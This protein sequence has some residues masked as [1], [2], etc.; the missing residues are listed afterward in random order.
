MMP[1]ARPHLRSRHL[2]VVN[3]TPDPRM[4]R[5][6]DL[7]GYTNEP[8]RLYECLGILGCMEDEA[9]LTTIQCALWHTPS[10]TLLLSTEVRG[11]AMQVATSLIGEGVPPGHLRLRCERVPERSLTHHAGVPLAMAP[12][13]WR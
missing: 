1:T 5:F 9:D 6:W 13:K 11:E 4:L 10:G 8:L 2:V 3:E 12:Y 7:D